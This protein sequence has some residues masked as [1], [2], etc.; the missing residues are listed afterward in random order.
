MDT[1]T[2]SQ[3]AGLVLEGRS[4]APQHLPSAEIGSQVQ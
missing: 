4:A 1:K 2:F 3:A